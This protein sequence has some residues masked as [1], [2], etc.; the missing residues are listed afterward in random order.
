MKIL[1]AVLGMGALSSTFAFSTNPKPPHSKPLTCLHAQNHQTTALVAAVSFCLISP[2]HAF[3]DEYGREVEAPT[4][5]TGETIEI[6]IKRGPLGACTQTER[7]TVE[8]DNDKAQKYF[9]GGKTQQSQLLANQRQEESANE[10]IE[11]LRQQSIDNKEK[12]EMIV[13]Q[14]TFEND[15]SATFG[16][17]DKQV[18]IMNTDGQTFTLLNNPQAMRLKDAGFIQGRKFVKQPTADEIEAAAKAEVPAFLKAI[19]GDN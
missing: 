3:A 4:F 15:Q 18:L 7:R 2:F 12:N 6:C 9:K 1:T 13:A 5:S 14:K 10:L 17:F 16:P 8:N 11:K 19:L